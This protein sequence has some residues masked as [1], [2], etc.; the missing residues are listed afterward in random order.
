LRKVYIRFTG[1][2]EAGSQE[3]GKALPAVAVTWKQ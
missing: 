1:V 3:L 2:T